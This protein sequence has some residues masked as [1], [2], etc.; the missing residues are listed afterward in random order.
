VPGIKTNVIDTT[1]I[2]D[3]FLRAAAELLDSAVDRK[4]DRVVTTGDVDKFRGLLAQHEQALAAGRPET[5]ELSR[6]LGR[7]EIDVVVKNLPAL[8]KLIEAQRQPAARTPFFTC[9]NIRAIAETRSRDCA[10]ALLDCLGDKGSELNIAEFLRAKHVLEALQDGTEGELTAAD[11]ALV[12]P[13]RQAQ[14]EGRIPEPAFDAIDIFFLS[15][16]G[17]LVNSGPVCINGQEYPDAFRLPSGKDEGKPDDLNQCVDYYEKHF[18]RSAYDRIYIKGFDG[19][20]YV[21]L[22]KKGAL[23]SIQEGYRVQMCRDHHL[24]DSGEILRIVDI[25]NSGREAVWG[26]WK[27]ATLGL[28]DRV[29]RAF[30]KA[31][32][33]RVDSAAKA[34]VNGQIPEAG[35]T[36]KQDIATMLTAGGYLAS[37]GIGSLVLPAAAVGLLAVPIGFTGASIVDYATRKHDLA[38]F[39][40][41][42]GATVHHDEPLRY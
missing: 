11:A 32:D 13:L 30:G 1:R 17:G 34:I 9:L 21:A 5:S 42:A 7:K 10:R 37:L 20:L 6:T 29:G 8:D 36:Q 26:Y 22:N 18:A 40:H 23:D 2:S 14:K 31:A 16:K 38:P 19:Q 3:S 24:T 41:A 28:L 35:R 33:D 15:G 12:D 39:Y 25:N 4:A 27:R